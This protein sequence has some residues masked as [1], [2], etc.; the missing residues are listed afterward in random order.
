MLVVRVLVEFDIGVRK[1]ES[2]RLFTTLQTCSRTTGE[3]AGVAIF[4][5][6]RFWGLESSG[7]SP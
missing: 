2:R 3:R 6:H 7:E 5:Q 1:F 4:A